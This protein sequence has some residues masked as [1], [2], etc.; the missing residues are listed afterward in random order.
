M[1]SKARIHYAITDVGGCSPNVVQPKASVLYMV[2]STVQKLWSF[3][4]VDKIAKGAAL[5]TETTF[6]KKFIDGLADTVVTL[7][8]SVF[9]IKLEELGVPQYTEEE[10][11]YADALAATYDHSAFRSGSR[12]R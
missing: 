5:M 9:F 11:K 6:E 3:R 1:S 4:N 8:W 12:K 10:N 2:R 7:R